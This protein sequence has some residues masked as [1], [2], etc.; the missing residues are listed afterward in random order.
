MDPFIKH[1][2]KKN[3][4]TGMTAL[5][6]PYVLNLEPDTSVNTKLK[7][8]DYPNVHSLRLLAHKLARRNGI[9]LKTSPDE[10]GNLWL[11]RPPK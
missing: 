10:Q 5:L 7:P 8:M 4:G 3:P 9:T 1:V 6:R 11:Y 2:H